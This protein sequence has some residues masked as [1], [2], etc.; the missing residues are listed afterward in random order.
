MVEGIAAAAAA[1][2]DMRGVRK[3]FGATQTLGGVD[4]TVQAGEA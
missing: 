3:R 4:L 2:L 1:R